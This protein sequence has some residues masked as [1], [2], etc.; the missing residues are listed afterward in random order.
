MKSGRVGIILEEVADSPIPSLQK[1]H[2]A[3]A[4]VKAP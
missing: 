4:L 2:E 3:L 1:P